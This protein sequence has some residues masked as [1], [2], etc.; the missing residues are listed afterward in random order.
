MF[1]FSI[2]ILISLSLVFVS[3]RYEG[4]WQGVQSEHREQARQGVGAAVQGGKANNSGLGLDGS[5][6]GGDGGEG[7]SG[8]V[9]AMAVRQVLVG[10]FGRAS[11]AL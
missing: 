8:A 4:G 1:Q 6:D 3:F 9:T 2:L 5:E 7:G 11:C 10:M